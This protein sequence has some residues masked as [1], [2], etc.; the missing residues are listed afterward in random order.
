[1]GELRGLRRA[2]RVRQPLRARRF[3]AAPLWLRLRHRLAHSVMS[4][5]A[6]QVT[7]ARLT[8]ARFI[9]DAEQCRTV[10]D[11]LGL[12]PDQ[13]EC[14]GTCATCGRRMIRKRHPGTPLLGWARREG[15]HRC[16]TCYQREYD[17]ARRTAQPPAPKLRGRP[18]GPNSRPR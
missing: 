17:R 16:Q 18:L 2:R 6:D 11:M 13:V 12:L 7:R 10:L 1:M 3:H 9:G 14:A 15:P 5:P 8:V 4:M